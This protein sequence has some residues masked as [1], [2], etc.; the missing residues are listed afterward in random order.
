MKGNEIDLSPKYAAIMVGIA[1]TVGAI[2]G[3][4]EAIIIIPSLSLVFLPKNASCY[5][6]DAE[7]VK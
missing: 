5:P 2:P 3:T 1:K 7:L 6:C 4:N